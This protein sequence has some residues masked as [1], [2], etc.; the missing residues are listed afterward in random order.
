MI[1][2][3]YFMKNKIINDYMTCSKCNI[4]MNLVYNNSFIDKVCFRCYSRS[5]NNKHDVKTNIRLKAFLE[6]I[7]AGI[8]IIYFILYENCKE[9]SESLKIN[10]INDVYL[11][12]IYNKIR[13]KIRIKFH[14]IFKDNYM[15]LEPCLDWQYKIEIYGSKFFIYL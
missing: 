13:N 6:E 1:L 11:G 5:S 9:L 15:G 14:K 7:K 3:K 4:Q 2:L 8:I 12:R 10:N